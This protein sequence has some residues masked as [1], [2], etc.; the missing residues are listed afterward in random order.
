MAGEGLFFTGVVLKNNRDLIQ[1]QATRDSLQIQKDQLKLQQDEAA[2]RRRQEREEGTKAISY[3]GDDINA[4]LQDPYRA[5]YDE[6]RGYMEKNSLDVYNLVPDAVQK[7][8]DFESTLVTDGEKLKKISLDYKVIKDKI[9]AGE[10]DTSKILTNPETGKFIFEENFDSI[11]NGYSGGESLDSLMSNFSLEYGDVVDVVDFVDPS[12]GLL[13]DILAKKENV[14][15]VDKFQKDGKITTTTDVLTDNVLNQFDQSLRESLRLDKNGDYDVMEFR[16]LLQ[17]QQDFVFA[18][19][20]SGDARRAFANTSKENGGA[21][22]AGNVEDTF[23]KKL[24]PKDQSFDEDIYNQYVEFIISEEKKKAKSRYKPQ[25]SVTEK[26]GEQGETL[27]EKD[28]SLITAEPKNVDQ[29][30]GLELKLD[31]NQAATATIKDVQLTLKDLQ[32]VEGQQLGGLM[33]PESVIANLEYFDPGAE[34]FRADVKRITVLNDANST[35]VAEVDHNGKRMLVP[36]YLLHSELEKKFKE[37]SEGAKL[38]QYSREFYKNEILERQDAEKD[39][40]SAE[41]DA[42]FNQ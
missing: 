36:L 3:S 26:T 33:E 19:G 13:D 4:R 40:S 30:N 9:A 41:G 29:V 42:L 23:L 31:A 28:L 35:P 12:N 39:D 14:A 16:A 22:K 18:D 2:A 17:G 7:R 34:S 38:I 11:V 27:T 24:D 8:G 1:E 20:S 21:G 25:V 10:I 6:Y 32:S 37:G 5:N 15:K